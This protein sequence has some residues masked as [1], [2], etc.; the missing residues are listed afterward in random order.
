MLVKSYA[1]PKRSQAEPRVISSEEIFP[2]SLRVYFPRLFNRKSNLKTRRIQILSKV[3]EDGKIQSLF[4]R[5][6]VSSTDILAYGAIK[7][8]AKTLQN[9]KYREQPNIVC[10]GPRDRNSTKQATFDS[11]QVAS[12][13]LLDTR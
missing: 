12:L 3:I 8:E 10:L 1:Q 9:P 11:K 6:F 5:S 7:F 13:W 4:F 2:T